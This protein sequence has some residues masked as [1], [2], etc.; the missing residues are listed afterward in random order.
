MQPYITEVE[1]EGARM[2]VESTEGC[3]RAALFLPGISGQV[4]S[5]RFTPLQEALN[6]AGYAL[7]RLEVW[8]Y[9]RDIEGKTIASIHASVRAALDELADEGFETIHAVGKSFGGGMLLAL[10]DARI[11]KKILWAPAIGC[12]H[13]GNLALMEN[14]PLG[15]VGSL[16]DIK[17]AYSDITADP[18]TI[19]IIHGTEDSIIPIE[20]SRAIMEAAGGEVVAIEG[21]DHSFKVKAHEEALLR[22]TV[23]LMQ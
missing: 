14:I 12:A 3:S 20:N 1:L 2:R 8:A 7:A 22:A 18:S 13:E 9:E 4:M 19:A 16:L 6:G 21:A 10:H 23:A 5:D 17:V 11:G 15:T